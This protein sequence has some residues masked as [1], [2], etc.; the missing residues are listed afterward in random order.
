MPPIPA[1]ADPEALLQSTAPDVWLDFTDVTSVRRHVDMA[2]AHGVC[3]VVGATGYA[4]TD[5]ERWHRDCLEKEIGGITVPNFAVGALLLMRFAAEAAKFFPTAEIIELHHSGKKDAPSGTAKRT[6]EG[7]AQAS[8]S[9]TTTS[10]AHSTEVEV[11]H[12]TDRSRGLSYCD[13]QIHSVRLPGL[14]AHQEVLFGG[15][16][17]VLTLRHDS[18]SRESFMPGVCIACEKVGQLRGM[19]Y[20][21]EH[22]LW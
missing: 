6:A 22:V 16:G 15:T 5:V 13:V 2:I 14:V 3:P 7:M 10:L 9:A 12:S 8:V 21:L 17:E 4:T 1:Y 18:L 20:G 11:V 19:V